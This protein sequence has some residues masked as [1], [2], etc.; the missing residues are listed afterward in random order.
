MLIHYI[1][2]QAHNKRR[3]GG[4]AKENFRNEVRYI[5]GYCKTKNKCKDCA[6]FQRG[7]GGYKC[8]FMKGLDVIPSETACTFFKEAQVQTDCD[9][10]K[11]N[12]ECARLKYLV[13]KK[14][15]CNFYRKREVK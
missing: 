9:A 3:S 11:K 15:E 12:G 4:G 13:C 10:Y 8:G 2:K 7:K 5:M 1:P 14:E 6:F